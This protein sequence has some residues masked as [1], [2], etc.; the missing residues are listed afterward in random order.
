M[1]SLFDEFDPQEKSGDWKWSFSDYPEKNCV[2]VF[3]CFAGAGGST[4]GY[5]LAGCEVVGCVEIDQAQ[6]DVYEKNHHPKHA[7]CMDLREFNALP[8]V[9]IPPELFDLDILDGSPPCTTFSMAGDREAS[10]GKKKKFREGQK[11]QTLDDLSF[12]FIET[13]KKLKPKVV[14]IENVEGLLAGEAFEYV[15]RIYRDLDAA[16]YKVGHTLLNGER[17]GIPQRRH[18]VFF[19]AIRKDIPVEFADIN[20]TFNYEPV[21]YSQVREGGKPIP[22]KSAYYAPLYHYEPHMKGMDDVLIKAEGRASGFNNRFVK[23]HEVP[24]TL[25]SGGGTI[26]PVRRETMST[27]SIRNMQT[28]PQD[29]DF[30]GKAAKY[31]CGMSVPPVMMKRVA[32][33][34]IATGI[35]E[36]RKNGA[37]EAGT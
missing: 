30:C 37:D 9:A 33:R 10:W 31:I 24:P 28:F 13:A 20:F 27:G 1:K 22:E 26:D 19:V 14:V 2:K 35:F 3:S 11:E 25:T 16:G 36:R 12:V 21:L 32:E 29:F 7:F 17:M 5:K 15:R 6:M 18:R 4:M 8:S 34:I 23:D